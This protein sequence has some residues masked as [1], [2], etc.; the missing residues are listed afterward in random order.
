MGLG[1]K[2]TDLRANAEAKLA[3]ASLL[4]HHG[5][6]SSAYYLAGYAIEIG[7]KACIARQFV[8]ETIPEMKF[9]TAVFQHDLKALVALAGLS[10]EIKIRQDSDPVF[11]VNWGVVREW[12]PQVRYEMVDSLTAQQM[13]QA[14]SN[15][16]SGVFEWIK[17]YW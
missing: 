11:G 8:A 2:R 15:E 14:V 16:T 17:A 10:E 12:K 1:H 4:L 6:F 13:L 5:H 9:V 7:L 3:S